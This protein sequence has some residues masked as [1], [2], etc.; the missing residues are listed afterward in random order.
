M[1]NLKFGQIKLYIM[2]GPRGVFSEEIN[3][4]SK[5]QYNSFLKE[6]QERCSEITLEINKTSPISG[7]MIQSNNTLLEK[8]ILA[9][10]T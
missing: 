1:K 6:K 5:K 2:L 7:S 4:I 10:L 9:T 3:T 8:R